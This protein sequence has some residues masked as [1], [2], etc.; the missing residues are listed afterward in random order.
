MPVPTELPAHL[1]QRRSVYTE[2]QYDTGRYVGSMDVHSD[3]REGKGTMYYRSGHVYDGMW[4]MDKPEGHGEKQYANGDVYRGQWERGQR[5]GFGLYLYAPGH[6]Y[7]GQF[8]QDVAHGE[9][10]LTMSNGDRYSGQWR[11]GKKDGRGR[12]VS[13][14]GGEVFV[15][16]WRAG[17]RQ[18]RGVLTMRD[19][20]GAVRQTI[21]GV[22]NRGEFFRELTLMEMNRN[23]P[24]EERDRLAD[25]ACGTDQVSVRPIM[26]GGRLDE[27]ASVEMQEGGYGGKSGRRTESQASTRNINILSHMPLEPASAMELRGAAAAA[28]AGGAAAPVADNDGSSTSSWLQRLSTGITNTLTSGLQALENQLITLGETLERVTTDGTEDIASNNRAAALSMVND[29]DDE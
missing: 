21:R 10:V 4:H 14:D 12:E 6:F 3:M 2:R 9:G 8:A 13:R 17:L 7:E 18:G 22:W 15:G 23:Q 29:A 20:S 5:S 1:T 27:A 25:L 26:T 19:A 24:P 11:H 16:Q 28:A